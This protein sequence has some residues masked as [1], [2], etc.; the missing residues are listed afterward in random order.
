MIRA[1][2]EL[3]LAKQNEEKIREAMDEQK[4]RAKA[5]IADLRTRVAVRADHCIRQ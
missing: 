1:L 5:I 2:E 3:L 4:Q